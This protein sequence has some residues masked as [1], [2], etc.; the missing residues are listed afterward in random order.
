VDLILPEVPIKNVPPP[1]TLDGKYLAQNVGDALEV[2]LAE[3]CQKRPYDPIEY[4]A[5]YLYKYAANLQYAQEVSTF[6]F[7]T[8][9]L[10]LK[11]FSAKFEIF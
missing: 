8:Y 11:Y 3:I 1:S 4:L 6:D 7:L 2:A 9:A 10:N 5:Q